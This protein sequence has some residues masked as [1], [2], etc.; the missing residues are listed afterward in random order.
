MTFSGHNTVGSYYHNCLVISLNKCW[1]GVVHDED[2]TELGNTD[3]PY[4]MAEQE[5]VPTPST[6]P[7]TQFGIDMGDTD[8]QVHK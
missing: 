4:S 2:M 8:R 7:N 3:V 1:C 5:V 6:P